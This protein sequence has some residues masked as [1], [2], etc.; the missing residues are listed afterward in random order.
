M[1]HVSVFTHYSESHGVND[2]WKEFHKGESF[3]HQNL[4]AFL[5]YYIIV[6]ISD[7]GWL[8]NLGKGEQMLFAYVMIEVWFWG[9]VVSTHTVFCPENFSF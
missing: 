9:K 7:G 5:K 4:I 6:K 8:Q 2:R 3:L 1:L